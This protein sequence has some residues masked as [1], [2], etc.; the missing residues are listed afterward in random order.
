MRPGAVALA[1]FLPLC[2]SNGQPAHQMIGDVVTATPVRPARPR[3]SPAREARSRRTAELFADAGDLHGHALETNAA[4]VVETNLPVAHALAHRFTGRGVDRE[5]LEQVACEGLVKAVHRFDPAQDHDFLSYAVPTIRGELQ[6][7]FRDLGWMVRPTRRVQET[8]W[9]T[10]QV[11]SELVQKLGRNPRTEEILTELGISAEEYAEAT[12][13][14]GCFHPTSLDQP[15]SEDGAARTIGELLPG[16]DRELEVSE[17]RATILPL[18]KALPE[19]DRRVVY[20]RFFEE[21]TQQEIGERIG[22]GQTQVSRILDHVLEE[23]RG[24]LLEESGTVGDGD[25]DDPPPQAA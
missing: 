5:D 16:D 18:V 19:R 24:R 12:S 2:S 17:A 25:G 4:E 7:Y 8:Q 20:L 15:T 11:E 9:R 1:T 10:A 6:R 3:Q 21:L 13:A 22:V 14:Q 23:L